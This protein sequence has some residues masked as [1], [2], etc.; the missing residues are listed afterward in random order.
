MFF[1]GQATFCYTGG[2]N[3]ILMVEWKD[4][5]IIFALNTCN[6][7]RISQS[8]TES[9]KKRIKHEDCSMRTNQDKI[10]QTWPLLRTVTDMDGQRWSERMSR[11]SWSVRSS[12]DLVQVVQIAHDFCVFGETSKHAQ[13]V[14]AC[15]LRCL[16]LLWFTLIF[17]YFSKLRA[18][19]WSSIFCCLWVHQ[20]RK[21]QFK[22]KTN[23]YTIQYHFLGSGYGYSFVNLNI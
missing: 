13:V 1:V 9:V 23:I 12:H 21:R 14:N 15:L 19:F 6:H 10:S 11:D 3:S 16:H 2:R 22:L 18:V 5:Q 20:H 7:I 8:R 17:L 4:V